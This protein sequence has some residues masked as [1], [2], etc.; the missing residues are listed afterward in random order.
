ML[1]D[2]L[3]LLRLQILH[4]N[5]AKIIQARRQA[6]Q[7][8]MYII[9]II[10]VTFKKHH[11]TEGVLYR[12]I[13]SSCFA[14]D[15]KISV[16]SLDCKSKKFKKRLTLGMVDKAKWQLDCVQKNDVNSCKNKNFV[17]DMFLIVLI[18]G[19][20]Y[21]LNVKLPEMTGVSG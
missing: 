14:Q 3:Y 2:M 21:L 5:F 9:M 18:V 19:N 4:K 15:G 8:L 13:C 12:H 7:C 16:Q 10:P 17:I 20:L 6:N 1:R 11:E